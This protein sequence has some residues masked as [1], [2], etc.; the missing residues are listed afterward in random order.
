[1]R[2]LHGKPL[3]LRLANFFLILERYGGLLVVDAVADVHLVGEDRLDVR[4]RPLMPFAFRLP[5]EDMSERSIS[6]IV[7]PSGC[8][9]MLLIKGAADFGCSHA[10]CGKVKYLF[11]DP[12]RVLVGDNLPLELGVFLVTNRRISPVVLSAQK[13]GFHCRLDLFACLPSVHFIE[14]IEERCDLTFALFAVH[15]VADRDISHTL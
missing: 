11:N 5:L 13:A 7:Q 15:A 1:M 4:R 10:M 6:L 3:V 9:Y 14:N 8:G 2:V 12:P